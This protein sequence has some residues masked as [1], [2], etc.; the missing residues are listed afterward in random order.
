MR[1]SHGGLSPYELAAAL[2]H[3]LE[4]HRRRDHHHHHHHK[5]PPMASNIDGV[6]GRSNNSKVQGSNAAATSTATHVTSL[7]AKLPSYR[8]T[9][10]R[11]DPLTATGTTF[12]SPTNNASG[13]TSSHAEGQHAASTTV[14][15]ATTAARGGGGGG[16]DSHP[17]VAGH[18]TERNK[19]QTVDAGATNPCAAS[20]KKK[21]TIKN[22]AAAGVNTAVAAVTKRG[23]PSRDFPPN[24]F[25]K[26]AA[27]GLSEEGG[28]VGGGVAAAQQ[29][30]NQSRKESR[31]VRFVSRG[32]GQVETA[33]GKALLAEATSTRNTD[34]A[35][36]DREDTRTIVA[37]VVTTTAET[38]EVSVGRN[39]VAVGRSGG[40]TAVMPQEG[41]NRSPE[42]P[43][44]PAFSEQDWRALEPDLMQ[45]CHKV[46][47]NCTTRTDHDILLYISYILRSKSLL[48]VVQDVNCTYQTQETRV[49]HRSCR[50]FGYHPVIELQ[51][52][53]QI[54]NI[55]GLKYPDHESRN[56]YRYAQNT[57]QT[58]Y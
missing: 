9:A 36:Q 33:G 51:S 39:G 49:L 2:G 14:S 41:T 53:T 3:I 20:A 21:N 16:D 30:N 7:S 4:S 19:N 50:L 43:S 58:S 29:K 35:H 28:A 57:R 31:K 27:A 23:D 47:K 1:L 38:G 37:A 17:L 52:M 25:S 24:D 26:E 10:V 56:L 13:T 54:R 34:D 11:P 32:E 22:T 42:W 40:A 12:N 15:Y 45:F 46:N 44:R 5:Q 6:A 55:S 18:S 8:G 48:Y